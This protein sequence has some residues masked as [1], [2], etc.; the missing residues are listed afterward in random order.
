MTSATRRVMS[1]MSEL[2]EVSVH[3]V[4]AL[5]SCTYVRHTGQHT[6]YSKVGQ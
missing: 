3:V 5:F 2:G 1:D 4:R 6:Y